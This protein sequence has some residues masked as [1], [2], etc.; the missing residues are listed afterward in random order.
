MILLEPFQH[1][2]PIFTVTRTSPLV[3]AITVQA[4]PSF[5]DSSPLI[6]AIFCSGIILS[7][8]VQEPGSSPTPYIL[9]V[10]DDEMI[11]TLAIR[12]L[13]GCG[14]ETAGAMDG[15]EALS[16]LSARQPD[17][18]LSDIKMPRMDGREL[19]TPIRT[20]GHQT[21]VVGMSGDHYGPGEFD[22]FLEKPLQ[23]DDFLAEIEHLL[24]AQPVV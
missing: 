4:V 24:V 8:S 11:R 13:T 7:A 22:A 5:H 16:M 6:R 21:P 20:L 18:I 1:C 15:E 10:D 23:L 9:V 12:I 19:R 2:G 3:A 17:L 14:Y